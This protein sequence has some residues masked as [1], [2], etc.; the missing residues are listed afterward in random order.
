M[1]S[2]W[3]TSISVK[4]FLDDDNS[5]LEDEEHAPPTTTAS[6]FEGRFED[7]ESE[8]STHPMDIDKDEL[9]ESS[10]PMDIDQDNN[11]KD[12]EVETRVLLF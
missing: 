3:C 10:H 2:T 4:N 5:Q 12:S 11:D 1:S 6:E 8:E 7:E 9:S